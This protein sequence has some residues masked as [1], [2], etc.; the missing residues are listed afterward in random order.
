M[1]EHARQLINLDIDIYGHPRDTDLMA[2]SDL[3]IKRTRW[4]TELGQVMKSDWAK[5]EFNPDI[6]RADKTKSKS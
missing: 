3:K 2:A 1:C 6:L 4:E 5:A